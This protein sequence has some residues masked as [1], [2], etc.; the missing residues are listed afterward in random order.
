MVLV[1]ANDRVLLIRTAVDPWRPSAGHEWFTPGGGIEQGESPV[2]AAARELRE[3]TG[4]VIGPD[5]LRPL[6]RSSWR[7]RADLVHDDFFLCRV[8]AHEVDTGALDEIE[9]R[10]NLGHHWWTY[11]EL[12]ATTETVYPVH[13]AA[14][15]R[16]VLREG[17]PPAPVELPAH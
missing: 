17:C 5:E 3:E 14:L 6:A 1:D 8:E 16:L 11:A 4:L 10:Y 2:Q 12:T 9:R 15:L 7:L 13:L